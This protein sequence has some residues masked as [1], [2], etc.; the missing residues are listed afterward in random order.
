MSPR[1]PWVAWFSE[2][3]LRDVAQAGGK[4]RIWAS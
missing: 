4:G 3:S 1:C 2:L